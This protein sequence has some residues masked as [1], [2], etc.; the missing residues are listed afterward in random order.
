MEAAGPITLAVAPLAEAGAAA[1][2]AV[3]AA[4]SAAVG[5]A[6]SAA[7]VA[8]ALADDAEPKAGTNLSSRPRCF[9]V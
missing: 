1:L 2:A 7:V 5:A 3:G 9:P 4:A 6:A 8:A